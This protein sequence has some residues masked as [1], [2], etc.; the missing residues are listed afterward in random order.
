M[1]VENFYIDCPILYYENG[2]LENGVC[3]SINTYTHTCDVIDSKNE[4]QVFHFDDVTILTNR[5]SNLI[6]SLNDNNFDFDKIKNYLKD[7]QFD[8][9]QLFLLT[10]YLFKA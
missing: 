7:N 8:Q 5:L 9:L 4:K 3:K 10:D 1:I 6:A 2:R